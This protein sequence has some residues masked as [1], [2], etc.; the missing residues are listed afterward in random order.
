MAAKLGFGARTCFESLS[1]ESGLIVIAKSLAALRTIRSLHT[2]RDVCSRNAFTSSKRD[3]FCRKS[4]GCF[5]GLGRP[6]PAG[7][8]WCTRGSAVPLVSNQH[9]P[10]LSTRTLTTDRAEELMTFHQNEQCTADELDNFK[11]LLLKD[12]IL[13]EDF[14]SEN[15][16]NL[17][18]QEVEKAL[19]RLKYEYDHWDGVRDVLFS[20][21]L[22]LSHILKTLIHTK[23]KLK[24]QLNLN[25]KS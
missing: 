12:F 20:M 19:K 3:N 23:E 4:K 6:R 2:A 25:S 15:E 17:L 8:K 16:E 22:C 21:S 7:A 11:Q 24:N 9:C 13:V 1:R 14:V 18:L 5:A 10:L